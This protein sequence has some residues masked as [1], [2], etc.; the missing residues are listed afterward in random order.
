MRSRSR[1]A[2]LTGAVTMLLGV[3]SYLESESHSLHPIWLDALVAAVSLAA[4]GLGAV[5]VLVG[6]ILLSVRDHYQ[7]LLR[8]GS[9]VCLASLVV[10]PSLWAAAGLELNFHDWTSTLVFPWLL[11]CLCGLVLVSIGFVKF[12]LSYRNNRQS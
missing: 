11:S 5:L 4:L 9:V 8:W 3:V 1:V 7:S 10:V 2:F 6:C 12:L